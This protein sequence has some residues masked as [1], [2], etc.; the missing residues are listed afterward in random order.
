MPEKFEKLS[1]EKKDNIIKGAM[2][3]FAENGFEKA[4]TNKIIKNAKISKGLLF[5]YFGTKKKLF[6]YLITYALKTIYGKLQIEV[7]FFSNDVFERLMQQSIAKMKIASEEPLLYAF[8]LKAYSDDVEIIKSLASE[9]LNISKEKEFEILYSQIDKSKFREEF[10]ARKILKLIYM[11]IDS[12]SEKYSKDFLTLGPDESLKK[13][14]EMT[15]EVYVY[16][17][18]IKK[19]I[20]K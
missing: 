4:S 12:I 7:A 1:Q 5:H 11:I 9:K 8:L 10:D 15:D 14:K 17:D 20:Y 18:M 19:G 6:Q 2:K 3:E 13:M 16:F